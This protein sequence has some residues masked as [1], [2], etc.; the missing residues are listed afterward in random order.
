M[1]DPA[2][3]VFRACPFPGFTAAVES[4][5][6]HV[7]AV[8]RQQPVDVHFTDHEVKVETL[9]GVVT[10][11][12]D[13]AIVTG[14]GGERW[15]VSPERFEQRYEPVAPTLAGESGT[16]LSLPNTVLAVQLDERFEVILSDGESKLAGDPG[17]WLVDY[18]DGSLGVVAA[19]IFAATYDVVDRA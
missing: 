6:R 4:D 1:N 2:A 19:E 18:G 15:P 13:A 3:R 5:P 12:P 17:D 7:V 14:A 9:E 11:D 10:A 8:K 16:Y